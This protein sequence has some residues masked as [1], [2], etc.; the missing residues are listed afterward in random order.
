MTNNENFI[1]DFNDLAV[2]EKFDFEFYKKLY[3]DSKNYYEGLD[4]PEDKKLYHHYLNYGKHYNTNCYINEQQLKDHLGLNF[5][6]PPC[7]DPDIY[8]QLY[9]SKHK[10]FTQYNNIIDKKYFIYHHYIKYGKSSGFSCNHDLIVYYHSPKCAGTS[11]IYGTILPNLYR[12]Y[13]CKQNYIYC[14]NWIDSNS[15]S[16]FTTISYSDNMSLLEKMPFN[17][18]FI[19][20]NPYLKKGSLTLNSNNIDILKTCSKL[21]CIII[22]S[23]GFK[24]RN[25]YIRACILSEN[26]KYD[27]YLLLRDPKKLQSSIFYYLRDVGFW[28]KTYGKFDKEMSFSDYINSSDSY[29]GHWLIRQILNLSDNDIVTSKHVELCKQELEKFTKIGFVELLD[30]FIDYLHNKYNWFQPRDQTDS[31]FNKNIKSK[32]DTLSEKDNLLLN[33]KLY[34]DQQLYDYFLNKYQE[35]QLQ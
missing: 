24:D 4:I 16:L 6:P 2:D 25:T 32:P 19:R 12:Q 1:A 17:T 11:I 26:Q 18:E 7:F 23:K 5:E 10:Y 27:Q 3:P 15:Y 14:I 22:N 29:I 33:M 28:E 13:H 21:L 31:K 8:E 35:K 30:D 20:K 9:L 34:F